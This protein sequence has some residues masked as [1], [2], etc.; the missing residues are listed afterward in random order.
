MLKDNIK[1]VLDNAERLNPELNSFLSIERAHAEERVAQLES[2]GDGQKLR[3]LAIAIK[4]NICT[5]GMQTTC[6]SRILNNYQGALRR[7]RDP[8]SERRGR[9]RGR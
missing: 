7:D 1:K 2:S 6:G 3:G 5:K 4:D 8:P 9:D